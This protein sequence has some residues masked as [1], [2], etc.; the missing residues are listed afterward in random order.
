MWQMRHKNKLK[1][2][3]LLTRGIR[4]VRPAFVSAIIFSFFINI[5][6]FVGPLYMLQIYDRVL[7][8]RNFYTLL[9]LTLIAGFLLV[10][11][12]VLEKIRSAVLV[13]AGLLFDSKTRS[14]LFESVLQGSLLQPSMS[15]HT[16]LRELD[17][18]REFLTGAGLISIL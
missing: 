13:R 12:A 15:H 16:V 3:N 2:D 5:L 8:S 4:E 14:E 6:A 7:S 11:Y 18:I 17:I 10:V 9:F 1:K